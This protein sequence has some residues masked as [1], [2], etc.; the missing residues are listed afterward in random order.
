M[1]GLLAEMQ[2]RSISQCAAIY[3]LS[4]PRSFCRRVCGSCRSF[5]F[6][7][8]PGP[9][10]RGHRANESDLVDSPTLDSRWRSRTLARLVCRHRYS[11]LAS[12]DH[13]TFCTSPLSFQGRFDICRRSARH[14]PLPRQPRRRGYDSRRQFCQ[15]HLEIS[16]KVRRVCGRRRPCVPISRG[17]TSDMAM[18]ILIGRPGNRQ[19]HKPGGRLLYIGSRVARPFQASPERLVQQR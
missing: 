11:T 7:W 15:G 10:P 16:A 5:P 13:C 2:R 6:A 17:S 3:P 18:D 4:S 8:P 19:H 1:P 9:G 12:P 14:R